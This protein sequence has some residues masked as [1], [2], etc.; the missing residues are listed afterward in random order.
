MF[1]F[2][3]GRKEERKG[4]GRKRKRGKEGEKKEGR[5]KRKK[6]PCR[7]LKIMF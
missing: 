4:E 6:M 3:V 7:L 5:N 2:F 1:K